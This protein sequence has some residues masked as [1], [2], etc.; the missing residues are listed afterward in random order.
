MSKIEYLVSA[1]LL[2]LLVAC[3]DSSTPVRSSFDAPFPK[4]NKDLTAILGD[5]LTLKSGD[6]TIHLKIHSLDGINLIT[7]AVSGDTLFIGQVSKFRNMYY[8]S[9]R[10]DDSSYWIHAIKIKDKLVYGLLRERDQLHNLDY[11]L[12]SGEHA[13]LLK[14]FNSDSAFIRLHTTKKQVMKALYACVTAMIPDTILYAESKPDAASR[15]TTAITEAEKDD[16]DIV[17]NVYPNP[18]ADYLTIE[19]PLGDA[20]QYELTDLKGNLV[21][22]GGLNDVSNKV[23]ISAQADGIYILRVLKPASNQSESIKIIKAK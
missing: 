13:N 23:D 15:L 18:V 16:Y 4:R 14:Y 1:A 22:S 8:L 19:I 5:E 2:I 10:I 6:D 3:G 12:L 20:L 11:D 7:N 21:R 9:R 17:T